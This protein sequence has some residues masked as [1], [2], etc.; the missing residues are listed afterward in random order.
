MKPLYSFTSLPFHY[1]VSFPKGKGNTF[2]F[3]SQAK[4]RFPKN[5]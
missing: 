1:R 3:I 5:F 2:Y 4:A